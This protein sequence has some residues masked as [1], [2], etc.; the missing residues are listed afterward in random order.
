[1]SHIQIPHDIRQQVDEDYEAV[2]RDVDTVYAD[3]LQQEVVGPLEGILVAQ[4]VLARA[5]MIL[6][7][8]ASSRHDL[9]TP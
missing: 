8:H 1:M 3:P 2:V 4:I 7:L 6:L 9:M 5:L